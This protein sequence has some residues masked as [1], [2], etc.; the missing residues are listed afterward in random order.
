MRQQFRSK[1][2]AYNAVCE[3]GLANDLNGEI[4]FP[5]NCIIDADEYEKSS[6]KVADLMRAALQEV[7]EV[8]PE[9]NEFQRLIMLLT[10]A[11]GGKQPPVCQSDIN[12]LKKLQR[13]V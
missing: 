10:Q 9:F 4:N 7:K 11:N 2:Q 13:L 5:V 8:L 12:K 1:L 6:E 3:L